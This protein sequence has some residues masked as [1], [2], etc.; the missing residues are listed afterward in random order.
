M[1]LIIFSSVGECQDRIQKSLQEIESISDFK[2][3]YKD[4]L[5]CPTRMT[6]QLNET[7]KTDNVY[8]GSYFNWFDMARIDFFKTFGINYSN[9]IKDDIFSVIVETNCKFK[10]PLRFHD[11]IVVY[12]KLRKE[13]KIAATFEYHVC[14]K[15]DDTVYATGFTKH[16]F[17][18]NNKK[19]VT[20]PEVVEPLFLN[21]LT[22]RR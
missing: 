13:S 20:L 12:T 18:N 19:I 15:G 8:N 17:V 21:H 2:M 14:K 9:F 6:I 16:V 10:K 3:E 4:H 1:E 5:G 11:E 7:D 22:S